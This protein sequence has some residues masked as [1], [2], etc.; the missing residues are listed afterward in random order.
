MGKYIQQYFPS[1]VIEAIPSDFR[2][3]RYRMHPAQ[4]LGAFEVDARMR[5]QGDLYDI[6]LWSKKR[7]LLW[8][9]WPDW[10]DQLRMRLPVFNLIL[11]PCAQ[12]A[13]G[14]TR[15]ISGVIITVRTVS[16]K[17]IAQEEAD[18]YEG[19]PVRLL[20]GAYTISMPETDQFYADE[21]QLDLHSMPPPAT[22][23][24]VEFLVPMFAKPLLR[25]A[26]ELPEGEGERGTVLPAAQF[27]NARPGDAVVEVR[28]VSARHAPD[29]E[30]RRGSVRR[31]APRMHDRAPK[32]RNS[33]PLRLPLHLAA[34]GWAP[35]CFRRVSTRPSFDR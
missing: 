8:P 22:S 7:T 9:V 16:G 34:L 35:S 30:A 33:R 2:E 31:A 15:F 6:N 28:A 4:R 23:D 14:S 29:P 26:V 25:I 18:T 1:A 13:D 20:R 12:L 10:Q 27:C 21:Q 24:A 17:T 11:R 19:V 3:S 32:L 5:M